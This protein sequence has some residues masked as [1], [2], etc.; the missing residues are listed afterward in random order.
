MKEK[1]NIE[2]DIGI[3]KVLLNILRDSGKEIEGQII[4]AE[5]Q[6][7]SIEQ[8]KVEEL[9][10]FV[11]ASEKAIKET[12]KEISE[13]EEKAGE[14]RKTIESLVIQKTSK[15]KRELKEVENE[16]RKGRKLVAEYIKKI[17]MNNQE[18]KQQSEHKKESEKIIGELESKHQKATSDHENQ[19]KKSSEIKENIL[20]TEECIKKQDSF[21][22]AFS[23]TALQS[24]IRKGQKSSEIKDQEN[25]ETKL[26]NCTD[27][28]EQQINRV[29][30]KI[31]K[32]GIE[33][34]F[35]VSLTIDIEMEKAELKDRLS[36]LNPDF[37]AI[38]EYNRREETFKQSEKEY[39][40]TNERRLAIIED[41]KNLQTRRQNQFLEGIKKIGEHVKF[42]Y[43]MLTLSGDAR[44]DLV[45][46]FDPFQYGVTFSVRPPGKSWKNLL[47]LSGGERT[48]SSLALVLA[49]HQF[50]PT[51][52]YI[53]DEVDAALDLRNVSIIAHYLKERA[54]NAQFIV[55]SLRNNMFEHANRLI[56]I[57]KLSDCATAL[58]LDP[59]DFSSHKQISKE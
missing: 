31:A 39:L 10:G 44:I 36:H 40:E 49:I 2:A 11:K 33:I 25:E 51:P 21:Y 13:M 34:D 52:F 1:S 22:Q 5:N 18:I 45:D 47:N 4:E 27:D 17:E 6:H 56:G 23:E 15:S 12:K 59:T 55:I 42:T 14:K 30:I 57:T 29:S 37:S 28:L 3:S 53:L 7:K 32:I 41:S 58:A 38:E 24:R 43:Q 8:E 48:L 26:K 50:K 9:K 54:T 46:K 20:K 19:K 16:E 35:K